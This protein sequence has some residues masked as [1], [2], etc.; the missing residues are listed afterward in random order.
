MPT[1]YLWGNLKEKD[2]LED[3][4]IGEK[5]PLKFILKKYGVRIWSKFKW[6]RI[7][8]SYGLI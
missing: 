3:V 7:G 2:L 5:T 8:L 1:K 4:G 6:I